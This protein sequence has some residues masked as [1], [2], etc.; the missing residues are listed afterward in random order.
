MQRYLIDHALK[1]VWCNPQQ[2]NQI[3]IAAQ[4][5]TKLNGELNRFTLMNRQVSLPLQGKRYHVYQIGQLLPVTLGLNPIVNEWE[6]QRWIKFSDAIAT[7]KVMINLYTAKGINIPRYSSYFMFTNDRDLI[8]AIEIDSKI[9][10]DLNSERIYTRFYSN[11]Y[12]ETSRADAVEDFMH[13]N[14]LKVGTVQHILDIQTQVNNYRTKAGHVSCFVNG[15]LVNNIS[16]L[17]AV[18]GDSIEYVYDS[19]VKK[20]VNFTVSDLHSFSSVLDDK[21]KYLLHYLDTSVD[22][23]EFQDDIDIHV[24]YTNANG[25]KQGVYYH[26]NK[27]DSHRMV[28]HRDYSIVVNYF[29]YV[30]NAMVEL[31]DI[32]GTDIRS[33]ELELVIRESGFDRP[34]IYD[35]SRIFELYKLED[36]KII[37]AMVGLNS[38]LPIWTAA[39]LEN[40]AYTYLMRAKVPTVTM[41]MVQNAYGYNS[42]SKILADTPQ[43]TIMSSGLRS[44]ELPVGLINGSTIYEYDADGSLLGFHQHPLGVDYYCSSN[45]AVT[46]EGIT[47]KGSHRPEVIFGTDNIP[48]PTVDN[49]RVYSCFLYNGEPNGVWRDITGSDDYTV[50]NNVLIWQNHQYD[51]VLMVRS[52]KTFLAYDVELQSVDGTLSFVITEQEDRGDGVITYPLPVPMG[53]LDI[54]LNGKS[55]INGLDYIIDFPKVHIVNKNFLN[56]PAA[57]VTQNVHVRFTGFC[58]SDL[59]FDKAD[60]YGFILHGYLSDNNRFDIRDDKVLR[61]TVNGE[62]KTRTDVVFSEE[63]D[64]VSITNPENGKPYQIKDIVVPLKGMTDADTYSMRSASIVIDKAVSDYMTLKKP[65]ANRGDL[66]AIPSKYPVVSTFFSRVINAIKDEEISLAVVNSNLSDNDIINICLPFEP[67]LKFDPIND[68]NGYNFTFVQAIPHRFNTAITLTLQQYRLLT[69]IVK[70]YGQDRIDVTSY[71]NISQ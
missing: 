28:T 45:D 49:Y 6:P 62:L 2:D 39:S 44:V 5:L 50:E 26:R 14:G 32:A 63:H 8:F 43:K 54:F 19:S 4:R 27:V 51:Q 47:G 66:M 15:F 31:L 53:E 65:E 36:S 38:S 30:A 18:I 67:L 16:P 64:G 52:D 70:L 40:N 48:L 7:Q 3:I 33:F 12:Y 68:D 34:L 55:L 69:R 46:V 10:V 41:S 21:Y 37:Q 17:T 29:E 1:N 56:Q 60:D 59:K 71:I 9:K 11:A 57:S 20:I 23:I 25:N 24:V 35:H 42:I 13:C 61:I 22:T 58:S